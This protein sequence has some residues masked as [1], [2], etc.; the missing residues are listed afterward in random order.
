LTYY[1]AN[2][3]IPVWSPT[4]DRIVFNS[5]RHDSRDLYWKST[6]GGD[7]ELLLRSAE[8]KHPSDWS[9]DG[10]FLLFGRGKESELAWDIWALPLSGDGKPFPVVQSP[11][12]ETHAQFSPDGRWIVYA[13]DESGTREL[14]VKPFSGGQAA[15]SALPERIQIT[16]GGG[17]QPRWRKDGKELFYK[18]QHDWIIALPIKLEPKVEPGKPVPLFQVR[19]VRRFDDILYEYDVAPDGQRFLFNLTSD[20]TVSPITVIVNWDAALR[21]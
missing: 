17:S 14:Y 5:F 18:D 7:E 3:G 21:R 15:S 20:R 8:S 4:A 6:A 10:K 11:F 19:G 1:P 12:S 9:S 2:E 16:N 13:S